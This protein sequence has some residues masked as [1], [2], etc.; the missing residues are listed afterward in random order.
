[1]IRESVIQVN[2]EIAETA[3]RVGRDPKEVTLV[4]V[5]KYATIEQIQQAYDAG[6]RNF[7]ES[8]L[9]DCLEK[10]TCLPTDIIWHFIGTLQS[11]K[12]NHAL[13]P[14]SLIHSVDSV[15]LASLLAQKS[16]ERNITTRILLQVNTSGEKTKQGFTASSC[17][18]CFEQILSLTGIQV[19]GLMTMAPLTSDPG[20]V[21]HC[22]STLKMLRN[23][24]QTIHPLPH[25][26]MGMSQD[27][28]IAIEEG[29]TLIRI[30]SR[31]FKDEI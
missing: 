16:K 2:E 10:I 14:F 15:K 22:F 20:V 11:N 21:R 17:R 19:E 28:L 29:A 5:C 7:A 18:S 26:S 1:M 4:G 9:P 12:I 6:I 13:G 3:K 27:F 24:L 31:L 30:G 25:L 8:R 23:E